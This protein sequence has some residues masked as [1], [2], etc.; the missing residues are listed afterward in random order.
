MRL[1]LFV[2]VVVCCSLLQPHCLAQT[3]AV[4]QAQCASCHGTDGTPTDAGK[5]LGAADLK[6]AFVQD[7]T[8][9]ELFNGIARADNHTAYAHAFIRRGMTSQQIYE[10]VKY[11]RQMAKENKRSVPGKR[12]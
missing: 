8:N 5:N 12:K 11:L 1:L 6:S 10:L 9:E 3:E 7:L 4:Y 2:A